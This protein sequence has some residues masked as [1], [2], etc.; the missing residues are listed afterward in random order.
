MCTN[1]SVACHPPVWREGRV[2]KHPGIARII[3]LGVIMF[4][5]FSVTPSLVCNQKLDVG[6]RWNKSVPSL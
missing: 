2:G 3:G 4:P 1:Q 6:N 5:S